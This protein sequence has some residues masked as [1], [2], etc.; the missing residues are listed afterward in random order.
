MLRHLHIAI[1]E[2]RLQP[3]IVLSTPTA[4]LEYFV[5]FDPA[6]RAGKM[7]PAVHC[8]L[9]RLLVHAVINGDPA[10][11]SNLEK[12]PEVVDGVRLFKAIFERGVGFAIWMEEVIV[13]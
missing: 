12:L 1:G 4:G 11:T 10:T 9:A 13:L 5:C 8:I 3:F 6:E 7:L 2:V